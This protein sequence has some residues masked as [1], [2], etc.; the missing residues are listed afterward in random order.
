MA[1]IMGQQYTFETKRCG[2]TLDQVT[3]G[4]VL[5]AQRRAWRTQAEKGERE[6]G[7]EKSEKESKNLTLSLNI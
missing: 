3:F 7:R 2:V 6:G 5:R 1:P 4:A